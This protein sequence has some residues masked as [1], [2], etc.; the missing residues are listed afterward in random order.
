MSIQFFLTVILAYCI[1]QLQCLPIKANKS[2]PYWWPPAT[3]IMTK[4]KFLPAASASISYQK[5]QMTNDEDW[6][7]QGPETFLV[8]GKNEVCLRNVVNI[9][10]PSSSPGGRAAFDLVG[11]GFVVSAGPPPN[12]ANYNTSIHE[13]NKYY[14]EINWK[15]YWNMDPYQSRGPLGCDGTADKPEC[16]SAQY[17]HLNTELTT[18]LTNGTFS[19]LIPA[20]GFYEGEAEGSTIVGYTGQAAN[21]IIETLRNRYAQDSILFF[22]SVQQANKQREIN[23]HFGA[24]HCDDDGKP[25]VGMQLGYLREYGQFD[26]IPKSQ[27]FAYT[28]V[29]DELYYAGMTYATSPYVSCF[30]KPK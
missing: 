9:F 24:N 25:Q 12:P 27:Q 5:S 10:T 28:K 3:E 20:Q 2:W 11:G 22:G 19:K 4:S 7:N 21:T 13:A 15:M 8:N 29:S 30:A 14:V 1:A 16:I 26:D 18:G 23:L 17:Q 6:I